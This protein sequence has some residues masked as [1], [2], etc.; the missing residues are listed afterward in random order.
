MTMSQWAD[1]AVAVGRAVA[2]DEPLTVIGH[3]YGGFIAQELA[4]AHPDAIGSLVLVCTTP[5]QLGRGEVPAPEG[6]PMPSE[7]ADLLSS[8]PDTDDEYAAAMARLAPP[9][10]HTA[11]PEDLVALMADTVFSASAMRRGFEV[12]AGWSSVDRLEQVT[13]RTLIVAGRHDPFTAWPQAQRI[14]S[15]IPDAEVVVFEHSSHFPWLDEPERFFD[16]VLGWLRRP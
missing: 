2:G 5:G 16:T 12:L 3:S 7:F 14:A 13:A 10:V 15:K 9:Y 11:Q 1:D 8:L 6:P 4:I